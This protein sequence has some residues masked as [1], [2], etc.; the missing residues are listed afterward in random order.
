MDAISNPAILVGFDNMVNMAQR[1]W[2]GYPQVFHFSTFNTFQHFVTLCPARVTFSPLLQHIAPVVPVSR[3]RPWENREIVA[4]EVPTYLF[5]QFILIYLYPPCLQVNA[6][7]NR[8]AWCFGLSAWVDVEDDV[9][10]GT[11]D[12]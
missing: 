1:I 7:R 9:H 12:P 6:V 4:G 10:T 3:I 8:L 5:I 2:E 11:C